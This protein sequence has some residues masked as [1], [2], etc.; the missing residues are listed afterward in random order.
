MFSGQTAVLSLKNGKK[1]ILIKDGYKGEPYYT[2]L[3]PWLDDNNVVIG[4]HINFLEPNDIGLAEQA[5]I[6]DP[7]LM[8]IEQV[9]W[10]KDPT[11]SKVFSSFGLGFDIFKQLSNQYGNS[12]T[13]DNIDS[14]YVSPNGFKNNLRVTQ[15]KW[16]VNDLEVIYRDIFQ[17]NFGNNQ[18]LNIDIKLSQSYLKNYKRGLESMARN[19]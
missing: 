12:Y 17:E 7:N 13:N 19:K 14:L 9:T 5:D 1:T 16:Q 18:K 8:A 2:S 11:T 3:T 10:F 4:L 15:F 6:I